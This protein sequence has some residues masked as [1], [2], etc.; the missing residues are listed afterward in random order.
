[1]STKILG[2][3]ERGNEVLKRIDDARRSFPFDTDLIRKDLITEF[4]TAFEYAEMCVLMNVCRAEGSVI[5]CNNEEG[6]DE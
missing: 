2:A 3:G 5:V 4:Q 6:T 1:M